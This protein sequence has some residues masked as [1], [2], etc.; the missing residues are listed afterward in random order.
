MSN[1]YKIYTD[2]RYN[3]LSFLS[4]SVYTLIYNQ[5]TLSLSNGWRDERGVFCYFAQK[6]LAKIFKKSERTIRRAIKELKDADLITVIERGCKKLAKIYVICDE[7][8]TIPVE[9]EN[10]EVKT[11]FEKVYGN[12]A[13]KKEALAL[14]DLA[15]KYEIKDLVEAIKRSKE[16]KFK[17]ARIK[18]IQKTLASVVE[19]K[20]KQEFKVSKLSKK[21]IRK[22]LTPDWLFN[23]KNPTPKK[24]Q[25]K[26]KQELLNV[27]QEST[28][29]FGKPEFDKYTAK[30]EEL[31]ELIKKQED[32]K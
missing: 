8:K 13:N 24:Q 26:L 12:I 29:Y 27:M 22:E 15:K 19:E 16:V 9:I 18:Y 3:D 32:E 2:E 1:I 6:E 23:D 11:T 4:K 21:V 28:K 31:K 10:S 25:T 5:Y 20:N 14:N 30:I 7:T 17:A